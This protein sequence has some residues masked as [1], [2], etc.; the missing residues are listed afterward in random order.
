[1]PQKEGISPIWRGIMIGRNRDHLKWFIKAMI[2]FF[3]WSSVAPTIPSS[4]QQPAQLPA[5]APSTQPGGGYPSAPLPAAAPFTQP[6]GSYPFLAGVIAIPGDTFVDLKWTPVWKEEAVKPSQSREVEN[7]L[8]SYIE[9]KK[10]EAERQRPIPGLER[11]TRPMPD[12]LQKAKEK[13]PEEKE[14]AGYIIHFGKDSKNYTNKVDIGQATSY[15]VRGLNNYSTY[16]FAVQAYTKARELSELSKEVSATPKEEKDLISSIERSFFEEKIPQVVSREMRQFG[17]EFFL[18]QVSSFAPIADVPVGPDYLIGPGDAF[19]ITLWGRVEASFP[20]EVDRNGEISLPKVGALKIWGL[21]FAQLQNFL[22][23]QIS[24]YYKDFQMNVTMEKLRTIRV[25]VVGEAQTPGNYVLSSLSTVYHALIAAGGPSKRGSLRNIQLLRNGKV[26]EKID[27]YDFFLR[28]DR[29]RDVRLQSGDTVFV[30]VI[31]PTVAVSGSVKRPAIYEL[32]EPISLQEFIEMAGGV[33]FQGYLQRVQVE[34][35]EAHQKKVAVDFDLSPE[36]KTSLPPLSSLLKD[37]DFVK[38][39]PIYYQAENIVFLEGHVKRPGSFELKA[40]M[41]VSDLI[42]SFE[43]L[44]SEPYLEYAEVNRLLPPDRKPQ[45]I[46]FNLGKLLAGDERQNLPLQNQDRLV[47]FAKAN[48]KELP[49]VSISGEVQAPGKYRLVEKMR[50]KDLVYQAG[51][52]RRSA[53]LPEAEVTRLVKTEKEVISKILTINLDA[54]LQEDLQHNI[55]LEEDDHLFVRQIPKWYIDKTVSI[56]G[57]VKFPGAYTFHKGEHLSS[58]LERAGGFTPEAYL[59]AAFFTRESVRKAQQKRIQEFIEEQ[60]QEIIKEAARAMEA[61]PT[62]EEAEQRQKALAQRRELI[63]RLKAV[64]ATGRVVIK[65]MDPEKLKGSEFDLELEDGDSLHVPMTPSTVMV[66]GR[67]YNPN[68]ILYTKDRTLEYYLNK[69]GGP[70][71]NADQKRIYLVKADGS[72]LSRTQSGTWGFRWDPDS[73]RWVSGGFMATR[74]D[75]G[76]SILVPEKYERI[77]WTRELRDWTQI[78]FNIAVA[79]GVLVALYK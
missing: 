30:P 47:I 45:T 49:Q 18:S 31:G 21:S 35:V 55:L 3:L 11:P 70:A 59:P 69:V 50:V 72:V 43:V 65:L 16:F 27:L 38:I 46:S 6:L 4:A 28:G 32:K 10:K 26:I 60:E 42:P 58:V 14:I 19:T 22:F 34:R 75:P 62:K 41:K 79:A 74:M 67:V 51:N 54:A 7:L 33:T 1:M 8:S 52:L 24:K 39:F 36:G 29:S 2:F 48:L 9:S 15:R 71:E 56:S 12:E 23:E 5:A 25:F 77:Y 63:A 13:I 44:L 68:A 37:G 73:N 57:E 17:Y 66:M 64:A 76:D 20:V 78:F 40:G 53:Y 61:A